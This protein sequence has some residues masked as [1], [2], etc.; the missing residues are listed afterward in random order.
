VADLAKRPEGR[1]LLL[2]DF[3]L[4]DEEIDEAVAYEKDVNKALEAS[5]A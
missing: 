2:D 3:A 5:A 4:T 1:A